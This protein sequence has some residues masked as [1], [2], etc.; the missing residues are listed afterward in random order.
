MKLDRPTRFWSIVFIAFIGF[1]AVNNYSFYQS[2][3]YDAQRE[4]KQI[5]NIV[6]T[7]A[8]ICVNQENQESLT[9]EVAD[10]CISNIDQ[11][12]TYH[13][14]SGGKGYKVNIDGKYNSYEFDNIKYSASERA[15]IYL[16]T[17]CGKSSNCNFLTTIDPLESSIEISTNPN[18]KL[19]L[20]VYRGVT[21]SAVE[22]V[23]AKDKKA[24]I[25]YS[26]WPRSR[27][28][29]FFLVIFLFTIWLLRLSIIAKIRMVRKMTESEDLDDK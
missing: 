24:F 11:L 1:V 27:H 22:L 21:F 16:S 23:K 5:A 19:W 8:H 26:A 6:N 7:T 29:I 13:R 12:L 15:P 17:F 14:K 28:A 9:K 3:K 20:S 25:K 2:E 4:L 18:P 10:K